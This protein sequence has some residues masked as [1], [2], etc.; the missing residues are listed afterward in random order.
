MSEIARRYSLRKKGKKLFLHD[1]SRTLKID[2]EGIFGSK[3]QIEVIETS[4]HKIFVINGLP[5]VAESKR[6]FFPVLSFKEHI[7]LLP[8]IVVDMGVVPHVC[9]GADVMAPGIVGIQEEFK[10]EELVVV[11]DERNRKPIAIAESLFDSKTAKTLEKGRIFKNLHHVGDD[12]WGI[13]K[14]LSEKR[15][16]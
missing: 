12:V 5:I 6:D 4:R 2:I 15:K 14:G 13:I 7:S 9:N 8:K 11:I 10:K 1:I 16:S 3:P